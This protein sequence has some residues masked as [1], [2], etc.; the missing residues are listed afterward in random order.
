MSGIGPPGQAIR[1]EKFQERFD[2]IGNSGTPLATR[3]LFEDIA[4]RF[5]DRSGGYTR[6]IRAGFRIGDGAELAILELLGSKLKK[7]EKKEKAKAESQEPAEKA[8]AKA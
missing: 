5:A 2:P 6:I 4:P 3:K 8:E 7:K 1:F